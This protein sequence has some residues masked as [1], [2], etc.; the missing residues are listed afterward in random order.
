MV[1]GRPGY[2]KRPPKVRFLVPFL[3]IF[4]MFLY[5]FLFVFLIYFLIF[6]HL[7]SIGYYQLIKKEKL[8]NQMIDGKP[9]D[10]NFKNKTYK[11]Y[12]ILIGLILLFLSL[13]IPPFLIIL[14]Y[15]RFVSLSNI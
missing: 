9:R 2:P 13:I 7:I 6:I 12:K 8:I 3:M 15:V 5:V 1:P 11:N 4:S 14:I 10:K